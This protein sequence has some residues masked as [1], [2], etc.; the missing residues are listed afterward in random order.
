MSFKVSRFVFVSLLCA[1]SIDLYAQS[2]QL[3]FDEANRLY[4]SGNYEQSVEKYHEIIHNGYESGALYFNLGNAYYKLER[5]GESILYYEKALKLT[6][7]DEALQR[8]LQIAQLRTVDKIE[9]IPNLFI[10]LW[11]IKAINLLSLNAF[12]WL[13]L[14]TFSC[15][16]LFTALFLVFRKDGFRYPIWIFA[17]CFIVFLLLF[18]GKIYDNENNRFGVVMA[19]TVSVVSEPAISSTEMFILHEGTKVKIN[20]ALEGWYEIS[21]A[22][23]KTGWLQTEGIAQI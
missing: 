12:S 16:A 2:A 3:L 1:A 5:I 10:E 7:G 22:D 17:I 9:P 21:L 4:T 6:P 23:G 18:L 20:R 19:K 13:S 11:W 14:I 15:L 8:N